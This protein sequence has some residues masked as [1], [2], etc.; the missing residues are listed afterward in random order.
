[1]IYNINEI[2]IMKIKVYI[3]YYIIYDMPSIP[4][5]ISIQLS[6]LVTLSLNYPIN[7]APNILQSS[8]SA[9]KLRRTNWPAI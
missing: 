4:I 1:M 9:Y 3:T 2:Y 7:V 5:E 8:L 6:F